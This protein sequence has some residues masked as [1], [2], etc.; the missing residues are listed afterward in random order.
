MELAKWCWDLDAV[1]AKGYSDNVVDLMV[2][3][4]NRLAATNQRVLQDFACIGN[5][6]E[7][8]TLAAVLETSE[9]DIE[10]SAV[11]KRCKWS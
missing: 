7:A 3:K 1:H 8:V 9:E 5:S 11:W 6:A 10:A 2:D 4:L